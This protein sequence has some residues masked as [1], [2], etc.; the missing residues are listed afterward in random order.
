MKR[1]TSIKFATA[2]ALALAAQGASA[3]GF[4][5]DNGLIPN[6]AYC[7]G[8]VPNGLGLGNGLQP[9]GIG[10]GNGIQGNRRA[11]NGAYTQDA[12][13]GLSERPLG[14]NGMLPNGMNL[15]G[16]A[17]NGLMPNGVKTNALTSNALT[18]NA[19]VPNGIENNGI[20]G[21]G[22]VQALSAK[23]LGR[24]RASDAESQPSTDS[25]LYCRNC[26]A[27]GVL[28]NGF[29]GLNGFGCGNGIHGNAISLNGKNLNGVQGNG[30]PT[31]QFDGITGRPLGVGAERDY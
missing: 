23:P 27:N 7:N 31:R 4:P 20:Q 8:L 13:R 21:N 24:Q 28:P 10:C 19:L 1:F 22:A 25:E 18:T 30:V 12:F 16:L 15:N 5:G 9:N 14:T 17:P 2:V 29:G 26:N 11:V 3:I 6:G